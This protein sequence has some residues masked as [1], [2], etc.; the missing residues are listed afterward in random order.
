V[1]VR[2]LLHR[3]VPAQFHD[4]VGLAMRLIRSR[5]PA[6]LF[7]MATAAGGLAA[8][9]LDLMMQP[10]EARIVAE[11]AHEQRP[12]IFVCGAPRSGTTVVYQ[13]LVSHLPVAYFSN[14]TALFPRSPLAAHRL[15]GR[16]A[17][18]PVAAY[19]NF[20]GRTQGLSGTNDALFLWDRWLGGDRATAPQAI[21]IHRGRAMQSFFAACDRAFARPLVN[22]NNSLNLSAHLVAE[23]L[24]QATFLCVT[25][26]VRRLARSLY[27]ARCDI[28]GRPDAAYGVDATGTSLDTSDAVAS[29]C[30]QAQ[31]YERVNQQQRDRLGEERFWLVPYEDFCRNPGALV[32]R[33][34]GSVLG[35]VHLVEGEPPASFT[36][37]ASDRAPADI[38]AR[39]DACLAA[40]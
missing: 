12:L 16:L 35:D 25:R 10:F 3:Y 26:D 9:P 20:Y 2:Q 39:I 4:P 31:F 13:T 22:K 33:V 32:R 7:A 1:A 21:E 40:A 19:Q 29:V 28:H 11:P 27:R 38:A 36:A 37:S 24:P 14:L 30:S 18:K 23:L 34:A 17:T 8:A 6:A 5:D 15:F